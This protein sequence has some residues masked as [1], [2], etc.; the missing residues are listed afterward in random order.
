MSRIIRSLWILAVI[1]L[2]IPPAATAAAAPPALPPNCVSS[3]KPSGEINV[4][5]IPPVLWNHDLVVFAHGYEFAYP[6][7][8]PILGAEQWIIQL[9]GGGSTTLPELV[10]ALGFGF[11]ATSYSKNGLTVQE[12][13]T[14]MKTLVET[15]RAD[16]PGEI[17]NVY[18]VGASEGGLITA[19]SM[20]RNADTYQGGL[21]LCGPVG[22]FQK[23]INY[24]GDFRTAYDAIFP[25][26]PT[27]AV[28][29]PELLM[30]DWVLG[31]PASSAQGSVVANL[32][33][34]LN[35]AKVTQLI[36]LTGAPYDPADLTTIGTTT[37]GILSYNVLAT[38][39]ARVELGNI[40]PYDNTANTALL[41]LPGAVHYTAEGDVAAA[42]AL[43]QTTGLLT[44]PLVTLH[45]IGDPIVPIWHEGYYQAKTAL[46]GASTKLTQIPV[47]RYGHCVFKPSETLFSFALMLY[48]ANHLPIDLT[49]FAAILSTEPGAVAEFL[50][51]N[52]QYGD[53]SRVKYHFPLIGKN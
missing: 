47:N 37:L 18:I 14:E 8:T 29:I 10:N 25:G 40:Q 28:A 32:S 2:S 42:L 27:T 52:A 5:C 48:K 26:L 45:N 16:H 50:A 49:P 11:A 15:V 20:E 38:N 41:A 34:P 6:A 24:W 43:Y 39:E 1:V 44:K 46:A 35:L 12:G 51:L 23:Q 3:V 7:S 17:R 30:A 33:D 22:D 4:V 21:A 19:L 31:L 13:V 36:T 9:S 53:I